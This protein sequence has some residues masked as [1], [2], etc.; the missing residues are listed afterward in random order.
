[1]KKDIAKEIFPEKIREWKEKLKEDYADYVQEEYP[2]RAGVYIHENGTK[3]CVT[4][5]YEKDILF[6]QIEPDEQGE[7][8]PR[9]VIETA[10]SL[11]IEPD[12]HGAVKYLPPHKYD[13]A[14][15]FLQKVIEALAAVS[16]TA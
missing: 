5:C 11:D 8:L 6:C 9:Q 3:I 1:M 4:L 14:Y 12:N 16:S 10:K 15:K 2:D 7:V 13:D